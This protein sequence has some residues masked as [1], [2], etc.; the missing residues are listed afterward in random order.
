[1]NRTPP[2]QEKQ[3]ARVDENPDDRDR[4]PLQVVGFATC[5][6]CEADIEVVF[7]APDGIYEVEDLVEAPKQRVSCGNCPAE[8]EAE[9]GGW[10]AHEDAG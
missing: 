9:W 7:T 1:M 4:R 10:V 2:V 6:D 5:P 8:F 3:L